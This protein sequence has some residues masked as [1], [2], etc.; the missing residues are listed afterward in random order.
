VQAGQHYTLKVEGKN[1]S[2]D[3]TFSFGR[4][5]TIV[6]A[7]IISSPTEATVDVIISLTAPPGI[8]AAFVK[9]RSGSNSGPGGV[10]I[11]SPPTSPAIIIDL[12]HRSNEPQLVSER[13]IFAWHESHPGL[14]SLFVFELTDDD[15]NV[16]FSA[17]TMRRSFVLSAADLASLPLGRR[18]MSVHWRV[19]GIANK[20]E[21]V[22][23]S[24]ER[25]ILLPR[26]R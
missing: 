13:T 7:P 9:N 18:P 8:A 20:T 19:V 6:G 25:S 15:D 11:T 17:Q 2:P 5:V 23:S 26:R 12:P 4:N 24:E 3:T 21:T 10:M 1:L 16:L 22:E 14:A